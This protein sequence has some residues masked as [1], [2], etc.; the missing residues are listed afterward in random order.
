MILSKYK[1]LSILIL[2]YNF[3]LKTLMTTIATRKVNVVSIAAKFDIKEII[4]NVS[5]LTC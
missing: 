1:L 2:I 5:M 4:A 3:N